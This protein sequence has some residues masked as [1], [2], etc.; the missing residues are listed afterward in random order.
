MHLAK[1]IKYLVSSI[2]YWLLVIE[3]C[4]QYWLMNRKYLVFSHKI[5]ENGLML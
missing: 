4:T 1:L 5:H 3:Y 2:G